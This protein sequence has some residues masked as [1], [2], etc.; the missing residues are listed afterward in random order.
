MLRRL[1]TFP[2]LQGFRG[3]PPVD[4]AAMEDVLLRVSALVDSHPELVEMDCHPV[5]AGP[6]GVVAVDARVRVES[7]GP[8]GPTPVL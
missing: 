8:P 2:L 3:S 5:I 4:I 1:R 6:D 7:A